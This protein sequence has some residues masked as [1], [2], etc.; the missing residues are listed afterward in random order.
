MDRSITSL[1][2]LFASLFTFFNPVNAQE[3]TRESLLEMTPNFNSETTSLDSIQ[4]DFQLNMG[5]AIANFVV[6]WDREHE[7]GFGMLDN[8]TEAPIIWL[9][10]REVFAYDVLSREATRAS[11]PHFFFLLKAG[12]EKA[13][14]NFGASSENGTVIADF[15]SFITSLGEEVIL[16]QL[17]MN[18]WRI[19]G[20]SPSGLSDVIATFDPN[21][22]TK[23]VSI[24][25]IEKG[26]KRTSLHI[27]NIRFNQPLS[28]N[29]TAL[30]SKDSLKESM[31]ID[32]TE[33]RIDSVAGATM[34][35]AKL[36]KALY[37]WSAF[38]DTELRKSAVFTL[39]NWKRIE[40]DFSS[41]A[42]KLAATWK[43]NNEPRV[44]EK[45]EAESSR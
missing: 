21:S 29:I 11:S 26:T 18:R 37:G 8:K 41:A 3:Q 42:P 38:H 45:P 35:I 33:Q 27:S 16:E 9:A 22:E 30:P 24:E 44:A 40:S 39:T 13:D 23:L 20:D 43:A 28:K 19:V 12:K 10:N 5:K 2:I 32:V 17:P 6:G 7:L 1:V 34:F 15:H 4:F 31:P 14:L 36:G 25:I